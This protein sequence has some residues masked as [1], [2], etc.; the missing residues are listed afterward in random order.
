MARA[1]EQIIPE[2]L[3]VAPAN[4]ASWDDLEARNLWPRLAVV[5]VDLPVPDR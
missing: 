5:V 2:P 1:W 4:E 3:T